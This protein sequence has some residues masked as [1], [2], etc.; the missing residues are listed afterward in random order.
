M[1]RFLRSVVAGL[2]VGL[3][4]TVGFTAKLLAQN[5]T[6]DATV[7]GIFPIAPREMRQHLTRAQAAVAEERFSDAV[8]EI[9]EILNSTDGDDFFLGAI[10]SPDAQ[11]SLKTQALSLLGTMPVKGRQMYELQY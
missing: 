10:G 8:F 4:F 5:P 1:P 3:I 6:P 2:A 9:G 11:V 7:N